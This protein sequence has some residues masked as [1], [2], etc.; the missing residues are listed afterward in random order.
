MS[1]TSITGEKDM[2]S[3][4]QPYHYKKNPDES[5]N[6]QKKKKRSGE[7]VYLSS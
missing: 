4:Q 3:L 2:Y 7:F 6:K 5:Q 1:P